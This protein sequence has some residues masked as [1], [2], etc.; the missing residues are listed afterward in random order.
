MLPGGPAGSP[1]RRSA[2]ADLATARSGRNS[3]LWRIAA[4]AGVGLAVLVVVAAILLIVG[5]I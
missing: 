3:S 5:V 2:R 4:I 1:R